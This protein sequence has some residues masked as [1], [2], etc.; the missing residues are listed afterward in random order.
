MRKTQTAFSKALI[1]DLEIWGRGKAAEVVEVALI[2][3]AYDSVSGKLGRELDRYEGLRDPGPKAKATAT[4]GWSLITPEMVA[5][6]KLNQKKNQIAD[7]PV[8]GGHRARA[9]DV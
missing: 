1:L 4:G 9:C 7:C 3:V 6:Q 5:G 8:R 2:Q